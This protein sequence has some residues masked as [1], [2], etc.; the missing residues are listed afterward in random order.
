M[1]TCGPRQ[2]PQ[3][4]LFPNR[5]WKQ[6]LIW[7]SNPLGSNPSRTVLH[8]SSQAILIARHGSPF[9]HLTP[10][11]SSA[12]SS[13]SPLRHSPGTLG[14]RRYLPLLALAQV[15]HGCIR[16]WC[17][18][19][20]PPHLSFSVFQFLAQ[21][22]QASSSP[23]GLGTPSCPCCVQ[24]RADGKEATVLQVAVAGGLISVLLP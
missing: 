24:F 22:T 3:L 1:A 8:I 23:Q 14:H 19:F 9:L 11:L 13:P 21:P 20:R 15:H 5:P 6:I 12:R 17:C 7:Y 2:V 18:Q 4:P 16:P 10:L